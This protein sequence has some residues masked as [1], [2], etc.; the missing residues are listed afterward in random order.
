MPVALPDSVMLP[1]LVALAAAVYA[2]VGHGGASAYL[3]ILSLYGAA[4]A[5][6]STTALMLNVLV[7]GVSSVT[8]ARAGHLVPRLAWPFMAT[9]V[10]AAFLGGLARVSSQAYALLLGLALLAAAV[11]L[12]MTL[13]E[14]PPKPLALPL[15]LASGVVIGVLSGV[16]G[17]GGGI[18][19]SPLLILTG[20]AGAKQTAAASAVFIVVNSVAGLAGRWARGALVVGELAPLV[21]VAFL[22]G[23]VGARI[24]AYR[25]PPLILRRVLAATLL[26]V[27]F[28]NLWTWFSA[29]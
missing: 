20:W 4:P 10:P 15:A 1:A 29:L 9:S 12:W 19:L 28:K 25:L 11:R 2:S 21:A 6:M 13:V 22:G 17:V 7:A 16:V 23:L 5:V 14:R 8:Y 24:G 27:A 26:F 18:F 3:A